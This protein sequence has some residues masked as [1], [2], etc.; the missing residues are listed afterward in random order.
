MAAR[1]QSEVVQGTEKEFLDTFRGLCHS[2]SAWQVWADVMAAIAC[3]ISNAIDRS[4]GH[5]EKRE[6][7]YMECIKRIGS[8]EAA[9]QLMGVIVVAL[10]NNPEQDF[11]G[12]M[13]M[14][15]E[16]SNHWKGQ[17]FTPYSVCKLMAGITCSEVDR[18]IEEQGYISVCDPACGAGATLIAAANDMKC[19][20]YNFQNHVLFVGQDVDRVV[21]QM[22]YIQLSLL[23][24]AG[25]ICV[26]NTISN[27]MV[28]HVLFPQER[29][30]QE[31]WYMPM[32]QSDVWHW[33][34]I[35]YSLGDMGG[36]VTPEKPFEKKKF[37]MFF[38][39]DKKEAAIGE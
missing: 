37:F 32:F 38:D 22:C 24:C 39:F 21:A 28:G 3:S 14:N 31:M 36:T 8:V 10:E 18:R 34:K 2:R 29:E 35:F 26:G 5:F 7:E 23:G 16:L 11:L 30:G 13:Y 33:R 9:A 19:S 27:P 12:K 15:L 4:P 6:Q 25:Y 1:K 20:K 17:F